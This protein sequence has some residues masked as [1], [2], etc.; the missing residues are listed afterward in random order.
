MSNVWDSQPS[1]KKCVVMINGHSVE[2]EATQP[3]AQTVK[4]LAGAKGLKRF[5]VRA[6]GTEIK[7]HNTPRTFANLKMVEVKKYDEA[8]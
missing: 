2:V 8:A 4:Q 3:F 1:S 7:G 5:T 6:D